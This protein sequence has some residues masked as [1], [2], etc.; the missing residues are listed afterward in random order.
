MMGATPANAQPPASSPTA[1]TATATLSSLTTSGG[2]GSAAAHFATGARVPHIETSALGPGEAMRSSSAEAARTDALRK[3]MLQDLIP[4]QVLTGM[5]GSRE[6]PRSSVQGL[7]EDLDAAGIRFVYFSPRNPRRS[8]VLADKMGLETDWNTAISLKALDA[9]A[10]AG[11]GGPGGSGGRSGSPGS[12]VTTGASSGPALAVEE[13]RAA[14]VGDASSPGELKPESQHPPGATPG[15]EGNDK[16]KAN[17]SRDSISSAAGSVSSLMDNIQRSASAG[18]TED[19]RATSGGAQAPEQRT[20][21]DEKAQLPHG[22]AEIRRHLE[23]VDDVPLRVSTF[24]DSTPGAMRDMIGI[25]QENGELVCAVGTGLRFSNAASFKCADLAVSLQSK[26]VLYSQGSPL[27][28]HSEAAAGG[29]PPA[30]APVAGAGAGA[31]DKAPYGAH[32]DGTTTPPEEVAPESSGATVAAAAAA[33][34]ATGELEGFGGWPPANRAAW[35]AIAH[36]ELGA[37]FSSL[38]ASLVLRNDASLSILGDLIGEAR[39]LMA[40]YR[41][42]VLFIIASQ[43]LLGGI[44][45][46]SY[47]FALP[48]LLSNI[49]VSWLVWVQVPLLAVPMI[50]NRTRYNLMNE[51]PSKNDADHEHNLVATARRHTV[52][53]VARLLPTCFA[54]VIMYMLDLAARVQAAGA[55]TENEIWR[56]MLWLDTTKEAPPLAPVIKAACELAQCSTMFA[57]VWFLIAHAVTFF[58]RH[59]SLWAEPPTNGYWWL[60]AVITLL[61]QICYNQAFLATSLQDSSFR[62]FTQAAN[63]FWVIFAIWPIVIVGMAELSKQ[64]D[65]RLHEKRQR[66]M[67]IIYDTRLGMHSPK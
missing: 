47:F 33:L 26:V 42:S 61:L 52:Y 55:S 7:I 32:E 5:V 66:R 17:Q 49:H 20:H 11:G 25:L 29:A 13:P 40:N 30:P 64:Q 65:R 36:I 39:L 58:S 62:W 10:T 21:W 12:P 1:T 23:E 46:L 31:G 53:L 8:L 41:Q 67:R 51:M 45:T 60:A 44:I 34:G 27:E 43:L 57:V 38:Q 35:P 63:G 16:I 56:A 19:L 54:V 14:G 24:T 18:E 4:A 28:P 9:S 2:G 50:S 48:D 59:H 22:I 6:Q 37:T 15:D 3:R